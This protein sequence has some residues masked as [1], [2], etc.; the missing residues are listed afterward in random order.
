[1]NVWPL[2]DMALLGALIGHVLVCVLF[3][4]VISSRDSYGIDRRRFTELWLALVTGL[5]AA[6][7]LLER[8]SQ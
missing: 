2:L 1:M 7:A 8:L 6:F 4:S 3:F 5:A